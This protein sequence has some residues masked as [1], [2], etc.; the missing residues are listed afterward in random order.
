LFIV[1]IIIVA[2]FYNSDIFQVGNIQRLNIRHKNRSVI[3]SKAL[4]IVGMI[5]DAD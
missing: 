3:A 1:L 2:D 5:P 4:L